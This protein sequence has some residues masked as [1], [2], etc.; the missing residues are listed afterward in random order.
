[1]E[2]RP[3]TSDDSRGS[4]EGVHFSDEEAHTDGLGAPGVVEILEKGHGR[5]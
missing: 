5:G 2:S 1:M 4:E 3:A